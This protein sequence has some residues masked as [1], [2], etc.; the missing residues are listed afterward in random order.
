MPIS[1]AWF[2]RIKSAQKD[3]IERCGGIVRSAEKCSSSKTEVGRWNNQTDPDLMPLP[4][5]LQ[6]EADCGMPLVTAVMADLNGRRLADPDEFGATNAGVMTAHAEVVVQF[7]ELIAK[8]AIAFSDGKLTPS[9]LAGIDRNAAALERALSELRK[10]AAAGR[11]QGGLSI[12]GG[13]A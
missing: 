6:L 11:G 7:G 3:L 9:E 13:V 5:V 10:A 2:Y 4:A 12:V 1:E 8:A